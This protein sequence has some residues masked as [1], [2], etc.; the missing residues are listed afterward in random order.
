[1][2]T[3]QQGFTLIE[4]MIVVAIIGILAAVAIPQY[5]NYVARTKWG[6]AHTEV[7]WSQTKVEESIVT[8]GTPTLKEVGVSTLSSHCTNS[9]IV[10]SDGT[11]SLVCKILGGPSAVAGRTITMTR[12]A[13]ANW[14]CSTTASQVAVGKHNACPTE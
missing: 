13:N 5:T 2:R 12:D 11:A 6:T 4:L 1:M 3:Q 10:A 9:L 7:S 8:G 14:V